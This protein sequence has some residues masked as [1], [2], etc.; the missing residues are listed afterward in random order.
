M[1]DGF[2]EAYED[3]LED[4]AESGREKESKEAEGARRFRILRHRSMFRFVFMAAPKFFAGN[5][6][7]TTKQITRGP[8]AST[9]WNRAGPL[10]S[11]SWAKK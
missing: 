9:S 10:I 5:F 8:T 11:H 3:E 6:L 7:E 4:G 2:E 1:E